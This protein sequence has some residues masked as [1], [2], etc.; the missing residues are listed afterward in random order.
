[1]GLIVHDTSAPGEV[2]DFGTI[3]FHVHEQVQIAEGPGRI[4]RIIKEKAPEP[5]N[6]VHVERNGT[7]FSL[8]INQVRKL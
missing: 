8:P 7:F 5:Y 3:D 4:V 6:R 2:V 1:M